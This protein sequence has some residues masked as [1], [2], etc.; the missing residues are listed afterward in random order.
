MARVTWLPAA[1]AVLL[2]GCC[3]SP[4]ADPGPRGAGPAT[5]PATLTPGASRWV[6]LAVG[7]R[8]VYSATW[9]GLPVGTATIEATDIREI[10]GR[11]ALHVSCTTEVSAYIRAVYRLK[12][13]VATDIDLQTGCTL[14]FSKHIEEGDRLKDEY[15][16]FD[17]GAKTATYYRKDTGEGEKT[18]TPIHTMPVPDGV[19]D[20]LSCLLQARAMS[21]QDGEDAVVKVNTD[22]KTYDTHLKAIRH[23]PLYLANFGDLRSILIDPTLEYEGIFPSKG[24][25]LL[26]VEEDTR[27]PLKLQ[28]EIKVGTIYGTL[29]R[30]DGA[31]AFK[32]I[33]KIPDSARIGGRPFGP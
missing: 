25:L 19:Q 16:E 28:I 17:P 18:F 32:P 3:L 6:P 27:V 5:H 13:E 2:G 22:E 23:Q 8:W 7:E 14:R 30:R 24:R 21:L 1:G 9:N 20:P 29:I 33:P 26:W 15:I 4:W 31:E 12:D 10:R 11:K